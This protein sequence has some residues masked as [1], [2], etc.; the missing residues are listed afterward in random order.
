MKR[1]PIRI[2]RE[3]A[4]ENGL[5]Q[6][7]LCAWDGERTHVVTY[8]V[9]TEDCAQAALGGNKIK[10][11]LGWPTD[12]RAEPS[13]VRGLMG[14]IEKLTARVLELEREVER[15]EDANFDGRG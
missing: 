2:A 8:G 6:V 1:L 10:D 5:R 12:L 14:E 11:A 9:S 15:L 3:V 13:R 4:R 7:I